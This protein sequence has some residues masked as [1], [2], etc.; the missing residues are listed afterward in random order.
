MGYSSK[1]NNLI[2]VVSDPESA[3][4]TLQP[5]FDKLISGSGQCYIKAKEM[6][7]ALDQW[8]LYVCELHA[9]CTSMNSTNEE[10]LQ[11]ANIDLLACRARVNY[12][13]EKDSSTKGFTAN[14]EKQ[15]MMTG[16]TLQNMSGSFP[17]GYEP[18]LDEVLES[19]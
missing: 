10:K 12:E 9:A 14:L 8:L 19:R 6:D 2:E 15:M 5:Y 13:A 16:A 11:A 3:Q 18:A 1:A 17:A 4:R 7:E